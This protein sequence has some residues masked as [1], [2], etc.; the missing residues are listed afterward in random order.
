MKGTGDEIAVDLAGI[1]DLPLAHL[2]SFLVYPLCC[3]LCVFPQCV[4]TAG[5]S[6]PIGLVFP[7]FS[8]LGCPFGMAAV[9]ASMF[10]LPSGKGPGIL[11]STVGIQGHHEIIFPRYTALRVV[12]TRQMGKVS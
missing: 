6:W 1:L 12:R 10:C 3:G 9:F 8:F 7:V 11:N 2:L 4:S 5:R